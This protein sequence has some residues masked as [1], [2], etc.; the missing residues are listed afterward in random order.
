MEENINIAKIL[1]NAPKGL[2]LYSPICGECELRCVDEHL[3]TVVD[4]EDGMY[5]FDAYGKKSDNGERL[6]FP[7]KGRRTWDNWQKLLFPQSIGSVIFCSPY[8]GSY[9]GGYFLITSKT[10][11][12]TAKVLGD[13]EKEDLYYLY[14]CWGDNRYAT[15]EE[16]DMFFEELKRN[17]FQWNEELKLIEAIE[18]QPQY[19]PKYKIGEWLVNEWDKSRGLFQITSIDNTYYNFSDN[20]L[21]YLSVVDY[22]DNY[23][24]ATDQELIDAGIKNQHHK[25]KAGDV[26]RNKE[27]GTV[28]RISYLDT[29]RYIL[30]QYN[31]E[32]MTGLSYENEDKWELVTEPKSESHYAT[33]HREFFNWIFDRLVNVHGE[34]PNFDYMLSL[35]ERIDDLFSETEETDTTSEPTEEEPF[36][37]DQFKPFDKVLVLDMKSRW[38]CDFYIRYDNTHKLYACISSTWNKCIPYNDETA[39]LLNTT[40]D[41]PDKYKTWED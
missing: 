21:S 10:N 19:T 33:P 36:T 38:T 4:C 5:N 14:L 27:T 17:R 7:S 31:D 40:D 15:R 1:E 37:I 30:Y 20:K 2:K 18:P 34:N 22:S 41:C 9:K 29:N 3:I 24:L 26:I 11:A 6:L 16:T 28:R 8:R 25:F 35:K 13:D 12:T 32:G 39:H 23:R